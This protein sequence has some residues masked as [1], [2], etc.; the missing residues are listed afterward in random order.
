MN[1]TEFV[2]PPEELKIKLEQ[3]KKLI[4]ESKYIVAFTGY[5]F[6]SIEL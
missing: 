5:K 1:T 6:Y 3:L 4:V 2:D